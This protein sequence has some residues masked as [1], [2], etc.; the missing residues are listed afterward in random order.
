MPT[1]PLLQPV[2]R[3]ARRRFEVFTYLYGAAG[4]AVLQSDRVRNIGQAA[5]GSTPMSVKSL[6]DG[7]SSACGWLALLAAFG[8]FAYFGPWTGGAIAVRPG[9]D[10]PP[11]QIAR[12]DRGSLVLSI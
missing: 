5:I 3:R 7:F 6:L 1:G 2:P 12:D 9:E 10:R 8:A 11:A 4:P